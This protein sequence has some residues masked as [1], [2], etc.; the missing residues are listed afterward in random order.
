MLGRVHA[1]GHG[2]M[3]RD[4]IAE[5]VVVFQNTHHIGVAEQRPLLVVTPGHRA[6]LAHVIVGPDLILLDVFGSGVPVLVT[7][8]CH[9]ASLDYS[10]SLVEA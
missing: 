4:G 1:V 7:L 2:K 5:G 10:V 8:F 3:R 6:G 9:T